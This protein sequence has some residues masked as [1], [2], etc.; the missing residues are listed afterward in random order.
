M[1]SSRISLQYLINKYYPLF[2]TVTWAGDAPN[3]PPGGDRLGAAIRPL[4]PPGRSVPCP[5]FRLD[6]LELDTFCDGNRR[7]GSGDFN[8]SK[9][10]G[11]SEGLP[12]QLRWGIID[13][14]GRPVAPL[15]PPSPAR[16]NSCALT[17]SHTLGGIIV[18]LS[19]A[20][21]MLQK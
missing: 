21:S 11:K 17:T 18:A 12:R 10:F 1:K 16:I 3:G 6:A 20:N 9:I 19:Q 13:G 2:P 15:P 4:P 14:C 7:A 5:E 8:A